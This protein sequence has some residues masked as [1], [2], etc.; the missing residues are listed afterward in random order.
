M[1]FAFEDK[2]FYRYQKDKNNSSFLLF[3]FQTRRAAS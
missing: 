2:F 3:C 1:L